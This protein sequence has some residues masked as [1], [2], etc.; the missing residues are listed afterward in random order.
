MKGRSIGDSLLVD[1][2]KIPQTIHQ[3][4]S[5]QFRFTVQPL[6]IA[7]EILEYREIPLSRVT[8]FDGRVS[9]G[10]F[11]C[12]PFANARRENDCKAISIQF[13]FTVPRFAWVIRMHTVCER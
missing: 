4:I 2:S 5:I 6:I 12:M 9:L 13:H 8:W 3:A 1:S 10:S 7:F 11:G